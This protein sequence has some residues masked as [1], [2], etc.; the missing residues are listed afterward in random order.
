MIIL[1]FILGIVIVILLSYIILMKKEIKNISG[2][3]NEYNNKEVDKKIDINLINKEIED[4]A[5]SINKHIDLSK[6]MKIEEVRR[7]EE[8]KEMIANIS[9][10]LR[11]PLTSI[12]GYVQVIKSKNEK[13][14]KEKEY[15]NKIEK[16]AKDLKKMLDDFFRLSVIENESYKIELEKINLSEIVCDKIVDFYDE[17]EKLGIEPKIDVKENIFCLGNVSET[18]RILENILTNALKNTTG[19][20]SVKILHRNDYVELIISNSKS[21]NEF[22]DATKVFERFYKGSDNS[23]R[24]KNTGI[25]LSIVKEVIQKMNGKIEATVSTNEFRLN[26]RFKR[27]EY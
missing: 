22:I 20:V 19:E 6:K 5:R 2:Q 10:D 9:H 13:D 17:F 18:E 21:N 4:L 1:V 25:G 3:L 14:E 23:R 8:L 24:G 16:R 15:L 27:I 7:K 26:C 11:T 12:I